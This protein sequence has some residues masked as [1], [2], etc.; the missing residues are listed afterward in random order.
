MLI[1]IKKNK[2]QNL[3]LVLR[4]GLLVCAIL[5]IIVGIYVALL[6]LPKD[7]TF[8]WAI[9]VLI[10]TIFIYWWGSG[11]LLLLALIDC[12]FIY[13]K[14]L[15]GSFWAS[16]GPLIL[17]PIAFAYLDEIKKEELKIKFCPRSLLPLYVGHDFKSKK[18]QETFLK[19]IKNS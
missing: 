19:R 10:F 6:P 13:D 14:P 9:L 3:P 15:E 4:I 17:I 5:S 8:Y 12:D 11:I 7:S 1:P 18:A 2:Y 16:M